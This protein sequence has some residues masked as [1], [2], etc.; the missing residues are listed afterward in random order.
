MTASIVVRFLHPFGLNTEAT[1]FYR[2]PL[3]APAAHLSLCMA[4]GDPSLIAQAVA[5][6]RSVQG[7]SAAVADAEAE[8]TRLAARVSLF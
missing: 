1:T 8:G 3:Q 6:Y 2:I 4:K 5:E 7:V